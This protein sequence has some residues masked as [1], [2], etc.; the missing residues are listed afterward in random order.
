[1]TPAVP[2]NPPVTVKGRRGRWIV[3]GPCLDRVGGNVWVLPVKGRTPGGWVACHERG[4]SAVRVTDIT[5]G[6]KGGKQ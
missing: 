4:K 6:K 1:M 5:A 3:L 2:V